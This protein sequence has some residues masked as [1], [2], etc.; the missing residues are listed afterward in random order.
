MIGR[1]RFVKKNTVLEKP[2][3]VAL[4]EDT[5]TGSLVV[6]A[7]EDGLAYV[8][9]DG[10]QDFNEIIS[11]EIV[12]PNNRSLEIVHAAG[13]QIQEYFN[14]KRKSFD[15]PLDLQGLTD[16]RKRV[17]MRTSQ[18]PFGSTMTYGEVARAIQQPKAARAVGGALAH[19]P[20]VLVIPCHRVVAGDGSMHGFSSPGGIATKAKLLEFEGLQVKNNRLVG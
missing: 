1:K 11:D 14:G 18:I 10:L 4:I 9:F 8:S 2:L 13:R 7:S 6:A 12:N 16:F 15:L 3:S 20:I 19:N 17:L 5:I